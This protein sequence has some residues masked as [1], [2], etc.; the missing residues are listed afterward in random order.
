MKNY[1]EWNKLKQQ[2]NIKSKIVIPKEREVYWVSIGENIGFEQNG[3]GQDFSR[4]VLIVKRFSKNIFFGIPLSTKIK[5]GSYFH[6]FTFL[7]KQSSALIVQGRLFDTKRLENRLGMITKEDFV[8]IKS[9]LKDLL[10]V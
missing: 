2:L 8:N 9:K 6:E 1:D 10:D 4:L 3:K 5:Q 7:E